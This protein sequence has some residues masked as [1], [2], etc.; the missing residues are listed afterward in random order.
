MLEDNVIPGLEHRI[1]QLNLLF[2]HCTPSQ[3]EKLW[4]QMQAPLPELV[5]LY[6]SF[7]GLA[8]SYAAPIPVIPDSFLGGSAPRLLHLDLNQ[9]N[10]IVFPGLPKILLSCTHMA[11]LHLRNIPFFGYI[12]PET[13]ATCL[14][15]L[16]S[17]ESLHL[18]FEYKEFHPN[19]KSRPPFPPTR[20]VLPALKKFQFTGVIKYFKRFVARIDAPQ[21]YRLSTTFRNDI[22]FGASEITQ[23]ISRTPTFGTCDEARFI[24]DQDGVL[25]GLCQSHSEASDRRMAEVKLLFPD[26]QLSTLAQIYTS[27]L[28]PASAIENIYIYEV[29]Y[30]RLR[31]KDDIE[32]TEWLDL[33]LS[34]TAVKNLYVSK[35]IAPRIATALQEIT[36]GGTTEV[37]S[38][39]EKFYL[40]GLQENHH[41]EELEGIEQFIS[42]RQLTNPPVAIS[43]WHRTKKSS[44]WRWDES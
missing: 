37:L 7:E 30:P 17:L 24:F 23:F 27:L 5:G 12:S 16:T 41:L 29:Q 39:L 18:G 32:N 43:A 28:R 4:T 15:T 19:R 40:E 34:F 21:L 20:I 13:M 42:A 25:L 22:D 26:R 33:L 1:S 38:T 6:L 31:W 35:Q 8:F 11:K 14:S 9:L 2:R 44:H 3:L 10:G 36:E